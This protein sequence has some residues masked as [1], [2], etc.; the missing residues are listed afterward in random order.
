MKKENEKVIIWGTGEMS[1]V[2]W[3]YLTTDSNY[4]VCAFCVD[5]EYKDREEFHGLPVVVADD[6]FQLYPPTKYKMSIPIS[7]KLMNRIRTEKYLEFKKKGYSFVTYIS[8]KA[9]YYNTRVGENC[10]IMENNVIQPF[11]EIGDNVIMWSGNHLG[12]HS[13]IENNCFIASHVVISG[14]T[15]IGESSFLGVNATVRDNIN[16]GKFNLIGAGSLI[17][18]NTEDYCVFSPDKNI[19]RKLPIKSVDVKHI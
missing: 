1:E 14:A 10:I 15:T 19:T 4:E 3:F 16:V 7:Y 12:H 17:L 18:Q 11:S 9:V 2:V 8:S 6:V 5:R 13:K